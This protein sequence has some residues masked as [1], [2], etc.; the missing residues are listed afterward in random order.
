ME[1]LEG[2]TQTLEVKSLSELLLYIRLSILR[3]IAQS[4]STSTYE[5]G[6]GFVCDS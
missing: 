3:W 2:K 5:G 6:K 1:Q 4:K